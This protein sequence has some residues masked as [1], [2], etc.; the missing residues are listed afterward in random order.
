VVGSR[1]S[2]IFTPCDEAFAFLVLENN[3]TYW[4]S[5]TIALRMMI[6]WLWKQSHS[7]WQHG[8]I[9]GVAEGWK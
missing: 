8:W 2:K 4:K 3:D 6:N 5:S 9:E 7:S 1:V